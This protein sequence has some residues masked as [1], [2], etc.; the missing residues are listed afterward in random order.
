MF[1]LKKKIDMNDLMTSLVLQAFRKLVEAKD[2]NGEQRILFPQK[3]DGS[4]RYSEQE[5]KQ[6]FIEV[7]CQSIDT[8]GL[9]YSVETPTRKK[10]SS[11]GDRFSI[12]SDGIS[13]NLDLCIHQKGS[14]GKWQ[15]LHAVEFKANNVD[16]WKDLV[17]LAGELN[18]DSFSR[19]NYFIQVLYTADKGTL[20][21]LC[22]KYDGYKEELK[23]LHL[24]TEGIVVYLLYVDGVK[25]MCEKSCYSRFSL[26]AGLKEELLEL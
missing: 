4:C 20:D 22:Q 7:I 18:A 2:R 24:S 3:R 5:F 14:D 25:R 15:R 17:K 23:Q 6:M 8:K 19:E 1:H 12:D 16:V 13:G 10:Y 11:K 9:K 26:E 21:S